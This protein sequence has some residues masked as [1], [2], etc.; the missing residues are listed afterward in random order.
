M[1]PTPTPTPNTTPTP[2]PA[3]NTTP[4][5]TPNTTPNPAPPQTQP[6]TPP[7]P[8]PTTTPNPTP[9]QH[10]NPTQPNTTHRLGVCLSG[11]LSVRHHAG[12][13][14]EAFIQ[15]GSTRKKLLSQLQAVPAA[16]GGSCSCRGSSC[17]RVACLS[18]TRRRRLL[19]LPCRCS[20]CAWR[21]TPRL[22][23]RRRSSSIH[24]LRGGRLGLCRA[25]AHGPARP[26]LRHKSGDSIMNHL[27]PIQRNTTRITLRSSAS[28]QQVRDHGEQGRGWGGQSTSCR[29][30]KQPNGWQRI[31]SR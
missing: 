17:G 30:G 31:E 20:R 12:G 27:Q 24:R 21:C 7:H 5:P 29:P 14:R 16:G 13:H 15:L 10:P 19:G 1:H 22:R 2:T 6:P 28:G 25:A 18:R 8:H 3:P 4:T 26:Q 9:T 11:A 23:R